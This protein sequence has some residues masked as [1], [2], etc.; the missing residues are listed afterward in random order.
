MGYD[1]FLI[2]A[3]RLGHLDDETPPSIVVAYFISIKSGLA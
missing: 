1:Y 3:G 2:I